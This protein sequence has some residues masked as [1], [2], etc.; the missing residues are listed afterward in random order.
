MDENHLECVLVAS[1]NSACGN[2]RHCSRSALCL[3]TLNKMSWRHRS[4]FLLGLENWCFDSKPAHSIDSWLDHW[5]FLWLCQ[6]VTVPFEALSLDRSMHLALGAGFEQALKQVGQKKKWFMLVPC[7][8]IC[9]TVMTVWTEQTEYSYFCSPVVVMNPL[10]PC[11]A[12]WLRSWSRLPLRQGVC[13]VC[14][15]LVCIV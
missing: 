9:S 15:A 14:S 11:S 2:C 5:Q 6:Y 3:Q 4:D 12:L 7:E 8:P 13:T 10:I 1:I